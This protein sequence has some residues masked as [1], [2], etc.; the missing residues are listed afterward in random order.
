MDARPTVLITGATSG[1]G[2]ALA[3]RMSGEYRLVLCG[4]RPID[5][6]ADDLP[7]GATYIQADLENPPGA[8]DAIETALRSHGIETLDRLIVNAGTGYYRAAEAESAAIIRGTLDVNLFAPVLLARRLAPLLEAVQG[9]LVLIGSVAHRGSANMPAYAASKAGLAG[10][11]RSLGSEWQ[12]RIAVQIIHPGPTATGMHQKAGYDPGR[13]SRLFFSS[14]DMAAEIDRLIQTDRQ[15]ATVS[16][17][18]RLRRLLIGGV[19]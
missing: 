1:I 10:L 13:L 7:E 12:G 19:S 18:A 16:T 3:N 17:G 11:A 6:C 15:T 2:L 9:K 4:R 5:D 14:E 8:V